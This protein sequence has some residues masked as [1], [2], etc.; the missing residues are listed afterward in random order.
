MS[1][2]KDISGIIPDNTDVIGD[3]DSY[4]HPT[5][6]SDQYGNKYYYVYMNGDTYITTD[7]TERSIMLLKEKSRILRNDLQKIEMQIY[8]L[9]KNIEKG[10][11]N[12]NSEFV[13]DDEF[14]F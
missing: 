11:I 13:R 2:K 5:Q 1:E 3:E 14:P 10:F 12:K 6:I 8:A 4:I 9:E 7:K